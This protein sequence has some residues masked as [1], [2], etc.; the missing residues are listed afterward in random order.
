MMM[1]EGNEMRK[2]E[3]FTFDYI[4]NPVLESKKVSLHDKN[5]LVIEPIK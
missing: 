2:R 3:K 4:E 5:I 1:I